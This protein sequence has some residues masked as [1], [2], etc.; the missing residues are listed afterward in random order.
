MTNIGGFVTAAAPLLAALF[1]IAAA[2]FAEQAF[3]AASEAEPPEP[4]RGDTGISINLDQNKEIQ[5]R[6]GRDSMKARAG[7]LQS[8]ATFFGAGAAV[9]AAAASQSG[10][11]TEALVALGTAVAI[12]PSALRWLRSS[13]EIEETKAWY[14]RMSWS[15]GRK[16]KP[17]RGDPVLEDAA[18]AKDHPREAAIMKRRETKVKPST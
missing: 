2:V 17:T 5:E 8:V 11:V 7:A 1:A 16:Y 6:T 14:V 12:I 18:F 10:I 4:W 15:L 13:Q 3:R 9:E